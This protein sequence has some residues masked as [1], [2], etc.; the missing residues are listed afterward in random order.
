VATPSF[1]LTDPGA[2][3][4]YSYAQLQASGYG[5]YSA[6][7]TWL[8][9]PGL[10]GKAFG[11]RGFQLQMGVAAIS[12]AGD[13]LNAKDQAEALKTN[14]GYQ[15]FQIAE[16][17]KRTAIQKNQAD[18][19]EGAQIAASGNRANQAVGAERSSYAAQGVNVNSG[20]ALDVQ[21]ATGNMAA[22]DAMTIRNNAAL[23]VWG[24]QTG[25]I[26]QETQ[27]KFQ[28]QASEQEAQQSL[29]LGGAKAA[30][31]VMTQLDTYESM[32]MRGW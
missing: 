6:G 10:G 1:E 30:N 26:Q 22:I 32:K 17:Q 25:S 7:S 23:K 2:H 15:K 8:A 29:A 13:I 11:T 12:A 28:E 27:Q 9:Q 24:I 3:G 21:V 20:S 31:Q 5:D 4:T 19:V 18:L 14:A 16:N